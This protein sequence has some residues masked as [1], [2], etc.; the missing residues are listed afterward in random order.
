[1]RSGVV[2]ALLCITAWCLWSFLPSNVQRVP[3]PDGGTMRILQATIG[4]THNLS[5]EPIWK[6]LARHVLPAVLQKQLLG[7]FRGKQ[8]YTTHEDLVLWIDSPERPGRPFVIEKAEA[9]FTNGVMPG[10]FRQSQRNCYCLTFP[11]FTR[12]NAMIPLRI[13]SGGKS[14]CFTVKNPRP[15]VAAKW[16]GT[17]L[18]Q[19]QQLGN[20]T[21][22]LTQLRRR[23]L[24][25]PEAPEVDLSL[26]VRGSGV[27]WTWWH[28]EAFDP[29]GNHI[30][31]PQSQM[32]QA[33][34]LAFPENR[35]PWR[36]KASIQEF[37]SLG[38]VEFPAIQTFS[39]LPISPRL[40][41]LG[42]HSAFLVGPGSWSL[43]DGGEMVSAPYVPTPV[44]ASPLRFASGPANHAWT[45]SLNS[46]GAGVLWISDLLAPRRQPGLRLHER[47]ERNEGRTYSR[48]WATVTN[49]SGSVQQVASFY[50]VPDL[51]VT[52]K[53]KIEVEA[54]SNLDAEF[55]VNSPDTELTMPQTEAS[56]SLRAERP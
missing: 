53:G 28:A 35:G 14:V 18:P 19:K 7:S 46:P 52:W 31:G 1:M 25:P 27:G 4:S 33:R 29:W 2:V 50:S 21:V 24:R 56:T 9:I 30:E 20:A 40:Q 55:F 23:K 8:A 26:Y 41:E 51:W 3:L 44:S 45:L 15:V 36:L 11:C 43:S 49:K 48:T 37:I 54:V 12:E 32:G 38:C 42:M 5:F 6:R 34:L 39:A 22:T 13:L 16:S 47:D 10:S 17:P